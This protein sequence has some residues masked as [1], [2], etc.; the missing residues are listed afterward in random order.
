[1]AKRDTIGYQAQLLRKQGQRRVERLE[2]VIKAGNTSQR[3]RD[4]AKTQVREIKS[5]MQGTRQYSKSGKRY[6]SKTQ[7][8]IKKQV[9][10]LS[11]AIKEVAPRY[12][13]AGDSFEVTQR[14]MNRAS[15]NAP[16][17]YTKTEVKVFYRA[18]QKIWQQEGVGEHNRNEAILNYYNDIR[19]ANGLSPLRLDEIVDY[20][21]E[22]NQR[23]QRMQTVEPSEYMDEEAQE[24]Y[25][26]AT[27][28]DNA[29]GDLGSPPGVTQKIVDDI[30]DAMENLF[31]EPTSMLFS[32]D[33]EL[34]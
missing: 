20:I 23:A 25:D 5:A 10:R 3:V 2:A 19:R 13:V 15:V 18:T 6:K 7:G 17:V 16:S 29:D 14:E 24:F 9:D 4:W 8:Y 33:T 31:V 32:S 1:M 21:L 11:A 27:K 26:V 30:R 28:A 12:T 34:A 22:A